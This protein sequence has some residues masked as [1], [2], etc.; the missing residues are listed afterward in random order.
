MKI[1]LISLDNWGL[2]ANIANCLIEKGHEV[3]VIDFNKFKYKYPS[4]WHRIINFFLKLIFKKNLKFQYYGQQIISVL[5]NKNEKQDLILTIKADFID[6]KSLESLKNYTNKSVAFFNDS[7][8]RYPDTKRI[9]H[10]FDEVYSFEKTDCK[11]Y[12]LKFKTNYIYDSVMEGNDELSFENQLFNI[13]SRDQ[14]TKNIIRIAKSLYKLKI[15]YNI[16]IFDEKRRI[17]GNDYV[18]VIRKPISLINVKKMVAASKTVLDIHRKN[19]DGLTFRVFESLGTQKKLVTTNADIKN[20][21]FYNPNN[22]LIIDAKNPI[23]P[24]LF[25]ETDY[26]KVPEKIQEKYKVENWVETFLN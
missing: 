15:N 9:L 16:I 18:K 25:F 12:D 26:E 3:T 4:F 2:N 24:K 11:K 6:E 21:D 23:F 14:R 1:T 13:S 19:Q 17:P 10:C 7:I 22:I 8:A 5:E 20:Y